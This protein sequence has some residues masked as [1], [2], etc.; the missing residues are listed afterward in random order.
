MTYFSILLF[1]ILWKFRYWF[2]E[3][4][5]VKFTV[6][7][8]IWTNIW[9]FLKDFFLIIFSLSW[10]NMKHF[11]FDI[12]IFRKAK[13]ICCENSLWKC[14]MKPKSHSAD[15]SKYTNSEMN[16][17]WSLSWRHVLNYDLYYYYCNCIHCTVYS[18]EVTVQTRR[19]LRQLLGEGQVD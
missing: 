17:I 1:I 13:S 19:V 6:K 5:A 7:I 9:Q 16:R 4:T 15:L 8:Q 12:Y 11:R 14:S 10:L 2:R 3:I 18:P